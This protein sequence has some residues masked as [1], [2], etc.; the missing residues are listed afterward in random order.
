MFNSIKLIAFNWQFW[1][2]L[3]LAFLLPFLLLASI[4]N[5]AAENVNNMLGGD[6]VKSRVALVGKDAMPLSLLNKIES[7]AR[8]IEVPS[9]KEIELFL[10]NDSFDIALVFPKNFYVDS[11]F[12]GAVEVYYNSMQNGDAVDYILDILEDYEDLMVADKI[13]KIGLEQNIIN[14]I[15]LEKTNTFSP[16]IMLYQI[17]EQVKGALSNVLNL[18]F[19][20]FVIWLVRNLILRAEF[21]RPSFFAANLVVIFVAALL[22]TALVF[23]GFQTGVNADIEGMLKS[24]ILSIQQLLV[25][26]KLSSI[27]WLWWPTWLFIIGLLGCL[28]SYSKNELKAHSR[29]FWAAVIIQVIA[30]WGLMPITEMNWLETIAPI[31]NV[32]AVGQ[33]ALKGTLDPSAWWIAFVATTFWAVAINF[34]WYRMKKELGVKE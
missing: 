2:R 8:I 22:A 5:I 1:F 21:W 25:W 6:P 19:V 9:R 28:T 31:L 7:E 27:L 29:T 17:M 13:Q 18:L 23:I 15:V 26:N 30:V 33:L 16:T 12:T 32:F 24:I 11:V 20:L 4:M 3:L 34:L 14:P 10:Y